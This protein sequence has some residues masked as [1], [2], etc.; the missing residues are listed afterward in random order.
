MALANVTLILGR[1]LEFFLVYSRLFTGLGGARK[2]DGRIE[3]FSDIN[4]YGTGRVD[5]SSLLTARAV[6]IRPAFLLT[7]YF[8]R[9]I[10]C[11]FS[12]E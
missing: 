3:P 7:S 1:H 2:G 10:F 6:S 11:M 9:S 4:A 8:F 5:S 12:N